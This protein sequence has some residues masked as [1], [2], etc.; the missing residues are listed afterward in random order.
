M[1][2]DYA[3]MFGKQMTPE[4][5][6]EFKEGLRKDLRR[7]RELGDEEREMVEI[8]KLFARLNGHSF[9]S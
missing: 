3:H 5:F 4:Q 2:Q 1:D 7:I 6:E 9:D 8:S